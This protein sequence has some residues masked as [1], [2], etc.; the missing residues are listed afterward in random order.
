MTTPLYERVCPMCE[1][2]GSIS[3]TTVT[4]PYSF[5]SGGQVR[6]Y[7]LVLK[8]YRCSHCG[9]EYNAHHELV[10]AIEKAMKGE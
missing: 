5:A 4:S 7:T 1:T 3:C 9:D 2:E 8:E 10:E 6:Q